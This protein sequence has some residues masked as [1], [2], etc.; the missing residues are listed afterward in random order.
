[1]P[2]FNFGEIN[3]AVDGNTL[4][5]RPEPEAPFHV[6]VLGDFSGRGRR[7][8]K[9]PLTARKPLLV[10]RDNFDEVLARVH[11]ELQLDFGNEECVALQFSELDD[12]HP[13]RLFERVAMFGKLRE[14]R[15][16]LQDPA[17]FPQAAE[18]LG[19]RR[20]AKKPRP[21]ERET[22]L[23]ASPLALGNLLD[24]MIEQT[25][26]RVENRAPAEDD[27]QKFVRR[28]TDPHLVERADPQQAEVLALVDRAVGNQMRALL[29]VP[30]FQALE[31]AWRALFLFVR[32]VET[33]ELLK[34]YLVDVSQDEL[35]AELNS[36]SDLRSTWTYRLLAENSISSSGEPWAAIL[37]NYIFGATVADAEFLGRVAKIA[38]AAH[39]P[40]LAAA[41]PVLLGCES[42]SSTPDAREWTFQPSSE[43]ASAWSALRGL[44]E[45]NAL[46]LA[47]PR[48]LLRLPYGKE[49]DPIESFSFEEM[50]EK[51]MPDERTHDNYLWGNPAFVCA[52]LLAQSF[53]ESGWELR[54]G[55]R[56]ELDR[57]PV[58]IY[59]HD[60]DS[61]VKPCAE[62]LMTV[63]TAERIMERGFIPLASVKGQDEVRVV[64]FQSIAQPVR[65]LAGRWVP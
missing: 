29:H 20:G 4:Q 27:L 18:E 44:P 35:A 46:G 64:R 15:A 45:A 50:A 42:I 65:A 61:E 34:V 19:L 7:S 16:R 11:P 55:Q 59:R 5:E 43:S 58:H 49:T 14:L 63:N 12:F 62:A 13:D 48:F 51:E 21:V 39:A 30:E 26:A 56:A 2:P 38:H 24:D 41:S 25:E 3:I 9:T 6:L 52:L 23:A 54:P 57:L 37:G 22:T 8:P 28:V 10:D 47:L 60:G 33:D 32:R 40:F 36:S 31:A 53:S 17:T 1:M